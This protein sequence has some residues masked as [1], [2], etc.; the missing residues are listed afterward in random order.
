MMKVLEPSGE[1]RWTLVFLHGFSM[2]A[3]DLEEDF[4]AMQRDH[5]RIC[6]PQ[7]PELYIPPHREC[8]PAWYA[9]LTDWEGEKEDEVDMVSLRASRARIS[10]LLSDEL[11]RVGRGRVLL[12]GL[13]QGGCM[14]LDVATR[15]PHLCGVCTLVSHRMHA[16][17]HRPLACPWVALT[18]EDDDV[19]PARWAERAMAGVSER[20]RV[21]DDHYLWHADLD[22]FWTSCFARA[23]ESLSRPIFLADGNK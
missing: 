15:Q 10:G 21:D 14:A 9:Y 16:S 19:F 20:W 18:A 1:H 22:E 5:W 13:S 4:R 2:L 8:K 12:G 17:R 23:E 6:L 7:A 3:E 11:R